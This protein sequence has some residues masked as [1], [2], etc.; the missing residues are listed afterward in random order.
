MT[1]DVAVSQPDDRDFADALQSLFK[2]MDAAERDDPGSSEWYVVGRIAETDGVPEY[3]VEA[4][5]R[6][7]RPKDEGMVA[8]STYALAER[9]LNALT[10]QHG[11][12][13]PTSK[14]K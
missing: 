6:V 13:S 7:E 12:R 10:A 3:A 9:R 2:S 5:H 14:N 11:D 1:D 8:T 4:Y